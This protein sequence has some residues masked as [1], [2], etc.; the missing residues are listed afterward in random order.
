M[1][2]IA[3]I[4]GA[5]NLISSHENALN[6]IAK[7]TR[8]FK[9]RGPDADGH[10][11]DPKG[12]CHLG[13]RRLSIIDTS[14]A[15]AQPMQDHKKKWVISFNGEIYNFREVRAEL[16]AAGVQFHGRTDTEVLVEGISRW[17][18]DVL[19]KLDGMFAFAAFEQESGELILARDPF[20]EKPLYYMEIPQEG[21]AFASELQALELLPWFNGEVGL[22]AI[23]EYL[24]FQ[25]IGAPRSIYKSVKKLEPGSCLHIKRGQP[26]KLFKYYQYIPGRNGQFSD[27]PLADL[28]DELEDILTRS[29]QRRLISDVPLGAFLS[30]GVDSSTVCAIIRKKL[31]RPLKTFSIGFNGASD[32]EHEMA[33]MF[34]KHLGTEHYDQIITPDTNNFL[35]NIGKYLDEPNGDTSCM[36]TFLL[37]QFAR[38]QVTVAI[39]GDGGDELFCGYGRYFATLDEAEK[40]P[41][42]AYRIGNSYYADRILV[43]TEKYIEELFHQVPPGL[44]KHLSELRDYVDYGATP[45]ACRLRQT[46]A[47]N[48]L[49]GAVLP[50]VDRMSM[51]HSLEVR[52]PYLNWELA[53][54]AEK[55]PPQYLYHKGKG[56]IL[57]REVAY[58]YLPEEWI[59]MP[60]KGFGIPMT[61]WGQKDLLSVAGSLLESSDS[62]LRESFGSQSIEKFMRRQQSAFS[63][64]QVWALCAL[65][66]WCRNHPAIL[67]K[68]A[69]PH[70]LKKAEAFASPNKATNR[71]PTVESPLLAVN[72]GKGSYRVYLQSEIESIFGE[73]VDPNLI[74]NALVFTLPTWAE[75]ESGAVAIPALKGHKILFQMPDA[76][77]IINEKILDTFRA[78]GLTEVHIPHA[79]G[80]GDANEYLR[81]TLSPMLTKYQAFK[82]YLF[83]RRKSIS[84]RTRSLHHTDI[85]ICSTDK[86]EGLPAEQEIEMADKFSLFVGQR[87][88]LAIPTSHKEIEKL[89][90]RYSIWNQRLFLSQELA[91]SSG[92]FNRIRIVENN[93]DSEKYLTYKTDIVPF[94]TSIEGFCDLIKELVYEK[95]ARGPLRKGATENNIVLVTHALPPGGAERQW[96]YLAKGL[97]QKG[98][99]VTFVVLEK[100]EGANSHY[101]PMLEKD[102]INV[103]SIAS[104]SLDSSLGNLKSLSDLRFPF[105]DSFG[106]D[107][108]KLASIL[109]DLNPKAVFA[110]LDIVNLITGAAALIADVDKTVLSFRNFAPYNFPYLDNKLFLN[111][112][113]TLAESQKITL[114]GNSKAGNNDYANW[115]DIAPER[116]G[117]IPNGIDTKLFTTSEDLCKKTLKGQ[118]G[119]EA[120][121]KVILG[122]FRLSAE[123][124]PAHFLEICKRVIEKMPDVRVLI[125]GIGPM[126]TFVRTIIRNEG[127]ENKI[128]M[129]GRRNDIPDVI[130]ISDLVLLTSSFEGMP[131]ILIEAQILGVPVVATNVGGIPDVISDSKTGFLFE[132]GD[133]NGMASKCIEL[134]TNEVRHKEISDLS[135]A[136]AQEKFSISQ[137]ADRHLNLIERDGFGS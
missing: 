132:I 106:A 89:A 109:T 43:Y 83:L 46:D 91:R 80:P 100:L 123:K 49:P 29:I 69:T 119:L 8:S 60:K 102:N 33:R 137:L 37:S 64:Y 104:R 68:L 135:K 116:I 84:L 96:C 88:V 115:L 3:G 16:E 17:G 15:G 77:K 39:S 75:I 113:K 78:W 82:K 136:I 22:E 2:G 93:A 71:L 18:T 81:I 120:D 41:S 110:Q 134:L 51:Q 99:N 131:N 72:V 111:V 73:L 7:M 36:P 12:R 128:I 129:L 90:S 122:V 85:S 1:C 63:T 25:Y 23:S 61:S 26:N 52:T 62:R 14:Q 70:K 55:I 47:E 105:M 101:L 108:L 50:K 66:S 98:Q 95:N 114:S 45:L 28:A 76:F 79:F 103:I 124:Q 4:Y 19:N 42:A 112:Y 35:I 9:H 56:K 31:G 57:L 107:I 127:L 6:L 121:A 130:S 126:E 67:P 24:M 118:L 13:H 27:R 34:S 53:N 74:P 97:K 133:V 58:R 54:F 117:F 32:S 48:Y 21:L 92:A 125:A 38:Q 40:P 94:K 86:I 5:E 30:G 59:N 11:S 44:K 87:Q 65:E 10:W 20:G